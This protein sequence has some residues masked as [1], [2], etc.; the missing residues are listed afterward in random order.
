M[1]AVLAQQYPRFE[2]LIVDNGS[3]DARASEVAAR[4]GVQYVGEPDGG[5]SR[6]R[7]RG[8]REAPPTGVVAY[9]DDDA[10]PEAGW[11]EGLCAEFT[12]PRVM[13]VTGR[14]LPIRLDTEGARMCAAMGVLDGGPRRIAVDRD[15]VHWFD[16]LREGLGG[17]ANMAVRSRA[18]AVWPGFDPRLGLGGA[19]RAGEEDYALFSLVK[20]GH[21]VVYT[22]S[23]VV[24]HPF[25]A[26][27][28]ELRA[29][30]LR[31]LTTGAAY[32]AFLFAQEPECR[33]AIGQHLLRR[34]PRS[35]RRSF[36]RAPAEA[37]R[38]ASAWREAWAGLT[39][40]GL[41]AR[42]VLETSVR[43]RSESLAGRAFHTGRPDDA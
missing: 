26:T 11:L 16:L 39:G 18:F 13:A 23:A 2:V 42:S 12:D 8:A 32:L 9:I 22:P 31:T 30:H 6:A 1:A 29:M 20:R 4:Y 7:N 33:H 43:R 38:L 40:V 3:R 36:S 35:R 21:R 14:I 41:F 37:R 19:L 27:A 24:R 17:G 25:P 28:A 34:L 5:L 10:I 15:T